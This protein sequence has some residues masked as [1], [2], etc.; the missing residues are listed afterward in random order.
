M[1]CHLEGMIPG[2]PSEKACRDGPRGSEPGTGPLR[3]SGCRRPG[4]RLS[5][6]GAGGGGL[7][8]TWRGSPRRSRQH[9]LTPAHPGSL[10][11]AQNGVREPHRVQE[12]GSS[13]AL[14]PKALMTHGCESGAGR[15]G[16]RLVF[17]PPRGVEGNGGKGRGQEKWDLIFA[18]CLPGAWCRSKHV[19]CVTSFNSHDVL[20]WVLEVGAVACPKL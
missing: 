3:A 13:A 15:M 8:R 6:K 5:M 4:P 1:V 17:Q 7:P 9:P 12:A 11:K 18:R 16:T 20:W 2:C 14:T 10:T 19:A